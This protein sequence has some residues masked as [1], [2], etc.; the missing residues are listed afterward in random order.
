MSFC[1]VV[2]LVNM[3]ICH[4]SNKLTYF[5]DTVILSFCSLGH[6]CCVFAN[7]AGDA[8]G[9]WV[10]FCSIVSAWYSSSVCRS[11]RFGNKLKHVLAE[12]LNSKQ[13]RAEIWSC[14][15]LT[16]INYLRQ[17]RTVCLVARLREKF[18]RKFGCLQIF[19]RTVA[20]WQTSL[21]LYIGQL[22]VNSRQKKGAE[23]VI[24]DAL[25]LWL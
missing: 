22:T 1:I 14:L 19:C 7:C 12:V 11:E 6:L 4:L 15:F 21:R 8:G 24:F 17:P 9:A 2:L 13:S 20:I 16:W 3:C 23:I 5:L 10:R 25:C 18:S